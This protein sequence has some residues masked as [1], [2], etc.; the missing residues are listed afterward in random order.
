MGAGTDVGPGRGEIHLKKNHMD[1][2][3][4]RCGPTVMERNAVCQIQST[5]VTLYLGREKNKDR[6]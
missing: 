3:P 6:D 1:G 4:G 2:W 5:A